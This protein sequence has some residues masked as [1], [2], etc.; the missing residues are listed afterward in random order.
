MSTVSLPGLFSDF[1]T[2]TP[3]SL[4]KGPLA[5]LTGTANAA[6]PTPNPSLSLQDQVLPRRLPSQ[7][8]APLFTHVPES[9]TRLGL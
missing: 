6:G 4:L 8:R 9:K 5:S 2:H 1:Q 3:D 7:E